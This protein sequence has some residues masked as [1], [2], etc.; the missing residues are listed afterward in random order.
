MERA[1]ALETGREISLRVLP[2]R[3]AGYSGASFNGAP[4]GQMTEFPSE[5]IDF[6]KQIAEAERRYL[7]GALA[8]AEGVRTRASELLNISYRSFRH[9]A[10]KHNL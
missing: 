4:G 10:K 1:V 9:Y 3:I 6:E 2:D 7:Q 8:K 5:G